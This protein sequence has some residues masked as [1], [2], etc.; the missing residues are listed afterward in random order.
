MSLSSDF[1]KTSHTVGAFMAHPIIDYTKSAVKNNKKIG[2]PF[3][4]SRLLLTPGWDVMG[5]K[6]KI[7]SGKEGAE[8]CDNH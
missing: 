4:V 2:K 6:L 5:E 8:G 7:M 1:L 3:E